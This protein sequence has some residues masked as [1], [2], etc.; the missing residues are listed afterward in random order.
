[1]T[2]KCSDCGWLVLRDEG[3]SNYTVTE[4]EAS[5]LLRQHPQ[6]PAGT[7]YD[8][9]EAYKYAEQCAVYIPGEPIQIDVERTLGDDLLSYTT[10]DTNEAVAA[11]IKLKGEQ[12]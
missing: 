11:F 5:C 2:K 1:M 12:V 7:S 9:D 6:L 3:Y 4:T 10:G 8:D